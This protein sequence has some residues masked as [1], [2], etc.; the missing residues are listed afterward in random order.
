M[1]PGRGP[2]AA[3]SPSTHGPLEDSCQC[4]GPNRHDVHRTEAIGGMC[5]V[6][7]GGVCEGAG[8]GY[9]R[10]VAALV[11]SWKGPSWVVFQST[12]E[13]AEVCPGGG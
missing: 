12:F 6:P 4:Y 3:H 9:C 2:D 1:E 7:L 5:T 11:D 10:H 8:I 13:A